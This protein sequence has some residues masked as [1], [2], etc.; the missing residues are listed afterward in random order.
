MK[1][2]K[3]WMTYLTIGISLMVVVSCGKG[4]VDYLYEVDYIY[5]NHSGEDLT[6]R[7]YNKHDEMF[8]SFNI[9]RGHSINTHTSLEIGPAIFYFASNSHEIG[10]SVIISFDDGKCLTYLDQITNNKIFNLEEYDNYSDELIQ[11]GGYTLYYTFTE[12]D[13]NLAVECE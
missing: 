2:K 12:E 9:Q 7:V 11:Q 3:I 10:D 4:N 1:Q 6:M 13:Y 5:T 8:K